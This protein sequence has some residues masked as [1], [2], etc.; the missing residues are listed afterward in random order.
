M[1]SVGLSILS[2]LNTSNANPRFSTLLFFEFFKKMDQL[3]AID[4]YRNLGLKIEQIEVFGTSLR[5]DSKTGKT[6][7][8][9]DFCLTIGQNIG[10][11]PGKPQPEGPKISERI[12]YR[13]THK[14]LKALSQEAGVDMK[15]I[16]YLD[17]ENQMQHVEAQ[18]CKLYTADYQDRTCLIEFLVQDFR[19]Y[20]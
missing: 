8:Y 14:Q 9:L 7:I 11:C 13:K 5:I 2:H 12:A 17:R 15:S 16:K 20:D 6:V 10:T 19:L 3:S 1:E 4:T 18:L